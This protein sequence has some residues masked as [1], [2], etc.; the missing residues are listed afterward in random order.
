[1]TAEDT[2]NRRTVMVTAGSSGDGNTEVALTYNTR[3]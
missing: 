1:V 2:A 3:K